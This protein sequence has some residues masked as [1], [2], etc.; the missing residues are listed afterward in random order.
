MIIPK[1]SVGVPVYPLGPSSPPFYWGC[2]MIR[3]LAELLVLGS[4]FGVFK[5]G[6]VSK[7]VI[8]C[9]GWSVLLNMDS[10]L[11]QSWFNVE[12]CWG[13]FC[14][15][16]EKWMCF[17]LQF[18]VVDWMQLLLHMNGALNLI[19][20]HFTLSFLWYLYIIMIILFCDTYI[21]IT[22]SLFIL[23]TSSGHGQLYTMTFH[24]WNH[25]CCMT[26]TCNSIL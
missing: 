14:L 18:L 5:A 7:A 2:L 3:F 1:Q 12:W 22:Q 25:L 24:H 4:C 20:F 16:G 6:W 26:H 11:E 17:I 23:C 19:W 8:I 15:F 9:C 10:M 21:W 13:C